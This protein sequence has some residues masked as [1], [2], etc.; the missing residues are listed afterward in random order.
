MFLPADNSKTRNDLPRGCTFAASDWHILASFWHPIAFVHDIADKPVRAKL[1]DVDLVIYK[2]SAGITVA[3]DLCPHR[4]TR[5]SAGWMTDD[6][7]VCPMHGLHFGHDGA[8]SKIPSIANSEGRIPPKLRLETYASVE[9]YGII[10]TC[11]KG[12]PIWQLP[13]WDGISNPALRKVYVP[14]GTWYAAASRHVENFNDVAHFPWVHTQSFGGS[15][16]DPIPPYDVEQTEYGLRF[17]LPYHEGFNRFD[18]GVEGDERDVV[19]TYELTYPFS[20][21]I[22][23]DPQGSDY[24]VYFADT[25]CPV[26]AR[27]TRIFQMMTDTSGDPD[28]DY[29]VKDALLI[30]DE[31]KPMV[32][33]QHPEEL[34]LDLTEEIHVPS[35]RMSLEYRRGLA[36]KFGLGAPIAS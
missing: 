34:P 31:D 7:I 3:R 27:E 32:E 14:E 17:E 36:S 6:Q 33:E 15:T 5:I 12:E 19:Y 16:V 22:K 35:D 2:T 23:I 25:V 1:L 11:L 21:L 13:D 24:V 18:D 10:W 20:T 26:S 30:N 9:R 4:G 8:C 29:W 28:T